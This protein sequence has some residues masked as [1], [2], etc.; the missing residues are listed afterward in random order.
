MRKG[1]RSMRNPVATRVFF[2]IDFAL[3]GDSFC[4]SSG[5][6]Q[7][8]RSV[9][10]ASA[11]IC[12]SMSCPFT[13]TAALLLRSVQIGP[14]VVQ[15]ENAPSARR[16]VEP[17]CSSHFRVHVNQVAIVSHRCREKKKDRSTDRE[18]PLRAWASKASSTGHLLR[19][20]D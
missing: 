7:P 9:T 5:L 20:G 3:M 8:S 16:A 14:V 10:A 18:S 2:S 4:P 13:H 1:D 19:L 6:A 11:S 17:C 15:V 12:G